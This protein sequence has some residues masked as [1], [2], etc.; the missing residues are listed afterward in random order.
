MRL[1]KRRQRAPG[2]QSS[3]EWL[4]ADDQGHRT[5][6][7]LAMLLIRCEPGE[8]GRDLAEE[9]NVETVVC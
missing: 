8:L 3:S 7:C 4:R 2:D 1:A 6:I 9:G 5:M